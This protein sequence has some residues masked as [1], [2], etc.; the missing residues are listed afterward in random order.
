MVL[1]L[2]FFDCS[3]HQLREQVHTGLNETHTMKQEINKLERKSRQNNIRLVGVAEHSGENCLTILKT[4]L[5]E[6]FGMNDVEIENA[7]R[8]GVE[9]HVNGR[10]HPK[11]IIAKVL[12]R[13][14]KYQIMRDKSDVQYYITDD[15]TAADMAKKRAFQPL[16]DNAKRQGKRWKFRAG[17]LIVENTVYNDPPNEMLTSLPTYS[18]P[19]WDNG[20]AAAE[21]PMLFEDGPPAQQ[22]W[23]PPQRMPQHHHTPPQQMGPPY[24]HHTMQHHQQQVGS[25]HPHQQQQHVAP[26]LGVKKFSNGVHNSNP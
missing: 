11:H 21:K 16:I 18:G 15:Q 1:A 3:V 26:I 14:D 23:G 5:T 22:Q 24:P 20:K 6:K 25:P 13:Q 12:R 4:I 2:V 17:R 7:H 10:R 9:R 19:S 8:T